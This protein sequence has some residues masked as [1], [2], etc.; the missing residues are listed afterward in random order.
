M[1][2]LKNNFP[3]PSKLITEIYQPLVETNKERAPVF[4][5]VPKLNG[6]L[7]KAHLHFNFPIR[8]YATGIHSDLEQAKENTYLE[9]CRMCKVKLTQ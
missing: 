1:K 7:W 3:E 9:A 5:I 4:S 6:R 8:F 2:I